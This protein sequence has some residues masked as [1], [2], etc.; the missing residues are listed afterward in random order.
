MYRQYF[1][2][3]MSSQSNSTLYIG[4]T[5][6]L[7]RRVMEHKSGQIPGFTQRYKCHKLV[8]FEVFSSID[9]AMQREKQL[10]KWSREKKDLLIDTINQD[11]NDL[12]V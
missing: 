11:R 12:S 5:N 1:T 3:I 4:V 2:Y 8:Y 7:E 9:E 10:K 6:D